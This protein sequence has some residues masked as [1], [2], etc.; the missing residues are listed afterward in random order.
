MISSSSRCS[1]GVVPATSMANHESSAAFTATIINTGSELLLGRTLNTHGMFLS[2]ALWPL[3]IEVVRQVTL[4]DGD[5]IGVELERAMCESD[6][7]LVTGGLGPTSDDLSAE[8]AAKAKTVPLTLNQTWFTHLTNKYLQSGRSLSKSNEKQAWL[9]QG[10]DLI[11]NPVGTACG[12]SF[13]FN[14]ARFYFTPG[15]PH[16]FKQM[17]SEPIMA[18]IQQRF[19]PVVVP[20]LVKLSCFGISESKL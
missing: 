2:Q 5:V 8:A 1:G 3:G 9:P 12:F 17:I 4:P 20:T 18:D 14:K 6:V 19:Q 7:V 15:V 13:T 10:S 16:E 11:D